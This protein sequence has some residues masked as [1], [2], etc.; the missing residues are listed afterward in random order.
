MAKEPRTLIEAV[1]YFADLDVALKH[2]VELRW[3]NGVACPT[4]HRTDV[5]YLATR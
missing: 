5:G 3:P 4:C 2:M 1:R